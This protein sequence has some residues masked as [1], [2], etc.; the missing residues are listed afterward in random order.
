MGGCVNSKLSSG[1]LTYDHS[2]MAGHYQ[3]PPRSGLPSRS[4]GGATGSFG[5]RKTVQPMQKPR[6][7]RDVG[8]ITEPEVLDNQHQQRGSTQGIDTVANINGET[9]PLIDNEPHRNRGPHKQLPNSRFGFG[10]KANKPRPDP[11]SNVYNE[12]ARNACNSH[13]LAQPTYNKQE[14]NKL[15]YKQVKRYGSGSIEDVSKSKG[16]TSGER[17]HGAVQRRD[18]GRDSDTRNLKDVGKSESTSKLP[19]TG[20]KTR[21]A[22]SP[23]SPANRVSWP[24]PKIGQPPVLKFDPAMRKKESPLSRAGYY[25]KWKKNHENTGAL[26]KKDKTKLKGSSESMKLI[27]QDNVASLSNGSPSPSRKSR[28]DKK[29]GSPIPVPDETF[30]VPEDTVT[31]SNDNE[32]ELSVTPPVEG[33]M[34]LPEEEPLVCNGVVEPDLEVTEFPLLESSTPIAQA[35]AEAASDCSRSGTKEWW[36]TQKPRYPEVVA[37]QEA[38]RERLNSLI[39]IDSIE[40]SSVCSLNSDDLMLE[41]EINLDD[42]SSSLDRSDHRRIRHDSQRSLDS[43]C[44]AAQSAMSKSDGYVQLGPK[45]TSGLSKSSSSLRKS[46]SP[47]RSRGSL[48]WPEKSRAK[49]STDIH[50]SSQRGSF[51]RSGP[52]RS[53]GRKQSQKSLHATGTDSAIEELSS[54]V[55]NNGTVPR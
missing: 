27:V 24:S 6:S 30:T 29:R 25:A 15:N 51:K 5:F 11:N 8:A 47:N 46:G 10:F 54:L 23:Q 42:Y 12:N 33:K 16:K 35:N 28:K 44:G 2:D 41:T 18:K 14:A 40:C 53:S 36:Q 45:S 17:T 31:D 1:S 43:D 32:A 21:G 22:P 55:N 37:L 20:V 3:Y 19:T 49:D 39:A 48:K 4:R 50:E 38:D 34:E 13:G 9:A 7:T 26:T 52:H